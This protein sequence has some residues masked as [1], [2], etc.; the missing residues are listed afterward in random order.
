MIKRIIRSLFSHTYEVRCP[1]GTARI[2]HH[3]IDKAFPL[4]VRGS[5]T[6][7]K[8][9][10]NALKKASA[11]LDV[12]NKSKIHALLYD[13]SDFNESL[14]VEFRSAYLV[15]QS[16]PCAN[17]DFFSSQVQTMIAEQARLKGIKLKIR[18]YIELVKLNPTN[19]TIIIDRYIGIVD[20]LGGVKSIST[21]A[22]IAIAENLG[23][24]KK[25]ETDKTK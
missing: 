5:D 9:E 7:M 8:T 13:F 18:A 23:E 25:W 4:V 16:N 15:F 17:A 19:S 6:H 21:A 12:E 22:Q 10:L 11:K 3:D 24:E 2:L 14:M 20:E 1:D